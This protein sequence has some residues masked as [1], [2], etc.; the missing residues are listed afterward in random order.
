MAKFRFF[1]KNGAGSA[2]NSNARMRT[3]K[4][5]SI[6]SIINKHGHKANKHKANAQIA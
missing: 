3:R 6:A 5:A 1:R 2:A 4:G